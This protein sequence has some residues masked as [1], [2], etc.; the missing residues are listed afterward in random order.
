MKTH[1]Q[2]LLIMTT[3]ELLTFLSLGI[4]N[5]A[6]SQHNQKIMLNPI[7]I[8]KINLTLGN[9][10]YIEKFAIPSGDSNSNSNNNSLSNDSYSF[11]GHGTLKDM[12][13]L[14]TGKG[15]IVQRED[16]TNSS[17]GRAIFISQNGHASYSFEDLSNMNGNITQRL[18]TAFFDSNSSGDLEFLKSK[19]GIYESYLDNENKQ[20]VFALWQL[21]GFLNK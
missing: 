19:V 10:I 11:I 12:K 18:G 15:N 17:S 14:A 16:G 9:P 1:R 20:G 7:E 8:Q 2:I 5:T 3:I 6:Y 4:W 21:R 13:I